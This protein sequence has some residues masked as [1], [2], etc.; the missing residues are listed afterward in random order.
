MVAAK[1]R[2]IQLGRKHIEFDIEA[3][4][5]LMDRWKN[6]SRVANA[7]GISQATFWRRFAEMLAATVAE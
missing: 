3:G 1:E 2:G 4:R 6:V 7:M 5:E